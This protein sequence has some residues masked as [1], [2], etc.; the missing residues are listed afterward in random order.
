MSNFDRLFY[1]S[2]NV[3]GDNS[4]EEDLK[5]GVSEDPGVATYDPSPIDK[6][7]YASLG[8]N[9]DVLNVLN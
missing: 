6:N 5:V 7:D 2:F 9:C 4:K 1:T 8:C 3:I